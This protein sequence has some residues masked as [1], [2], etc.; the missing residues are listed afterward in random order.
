MQS[1]GIGTAPPIAAVPKLGSDRSE[2]K[3]S[4]WH[5]WSRVELCTLRDEVVEL[6]HRL[7]DSIVRLD[8]LERPVRLD[9]GAEL[10]RNA[11]RVGSGMAKDAIWIRQSL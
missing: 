7:V 6:G 2:A 1:P 3:S 9:A 5:N 10:V 8:L 4:A 11:K